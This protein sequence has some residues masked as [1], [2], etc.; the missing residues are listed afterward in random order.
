MRID[1]AGSDDMAIGVDLVASTAGDRT[2]L[3]DAAVVDPDVRVVSGTTGAIH[4]LC[5]S[6]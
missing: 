4:D 6:D 1:E 2:D 3:N 5:T